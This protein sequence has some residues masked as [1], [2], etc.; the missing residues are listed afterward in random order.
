M[1]SDNN[2]A[3]ESKVQKPASNF[4]AHVNNYK[5]YLDRLKQGG[6]SGISH[7][8]G[9]SS[10]LLPDKIEKEEESEEDD[11]ELDDQ[12]ATTSEEV[13]HSRGEVPSREHI[14]DL[15]VTSKTGALLWDVRFDHEGVAE[16]NKA[17]GVLMIKTS[18]PDMFAIIGPPGIER[19]AEIV[20]EI[21]VDPATGNIY[22]QST[23]GTHAVALLNNGFRIDQFQQTAATKFLVT[24][25]LRQGE[26]SSQPIEVRNLQLDQEARLLS[27]ETLN[28]DHSI[29][30]PFHDIK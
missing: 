23:D 15:R 2:D 7:V 28:N 6:S 21:V 18:R 30:I 26:T 13:F 16:I 27:Y 10:E 3:A 24:P 19:R 25:P 9:H 1:M 29:T 5:T 17:D 8:F 11:Q 14:A 20:S 12:T 4:H 22:Y